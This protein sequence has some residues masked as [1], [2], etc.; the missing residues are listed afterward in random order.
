VSDRDTKVSVV[1]GAWLMHTE[2]CASENN[3]KGVGAFPCNCGLDA[4]LRSLQPASGEKYRIIRDKPGTGWAFAVGSSYPHEGFATAEAAEKAAIEYTRATSGEKAPPTAPAAGMT[5]A[6]REALE[7]A[8]LCL[9]SN[10]WNL[11][12]TFVSYH[13]CE[14]DGQVWRANDGKRYFTEGEA[15][16]VF[17]ERLDACVATLRS[18]AARLGG[19]K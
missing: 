13:G 8:A 2:E 4:A 3:A 14:N 9:K 12:E 15:R 19:G 7:L 17:G 5:E 18:L 11:V 1:L 16:H 6:E 10:R